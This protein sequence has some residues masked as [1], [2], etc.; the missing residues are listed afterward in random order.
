MTIDQM[1]MEGAIR[2]LLVEL[3]RDNAPELPLVRVQALAGRIFTEF[4]WETISPAS[5]SR[6]ADQMRHLVEREVEKQRNLNHGTG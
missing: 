5:A 4:C 3:V 6:M 2:T 1:D